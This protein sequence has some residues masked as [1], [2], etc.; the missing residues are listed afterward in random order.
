MRK[1]KKIQ[2]QEMIPEV[3]HDTLTFLEM[4]APSIVRFNIDHFICGNTYRCIWAVREYP[5]STEEQAILHRLGEKDG[6]TLKIYTRHVTALEE[7]KI[8]HN[9]SNRNRMRQNT[10]DM[11]ENITASS[12]LQ[13]VETIITT[14]HRNREP[15]LHTAVYIELTANDMEKLKL[16]QT[17]VETELMRSKLNVDKLLMRQKEGF[18]C[19]MPTGC[20]LFKEQFERVLP[21]SSVANL[22]PFAYSGKTDPNGFYLGKDKYGSNILVDFEKRESD[23]TNS[24]IL[25]LGNSGQGKSYLLKLILTCLRE[26]GK[27]IVCLDPEFEYGELTKNLGGTYI[28]LM[29]GEYIINVLEPKLWHDGS[30]DSKEDEDAP[31]TFKQQSRMSQHIS[32]L[33]DFFRSYKDFT[34]AQIDTIEIMLEQLY[35]DFNISDETDFSQMNPSD[36]PILSDLY[37]LCEREFKHYDAKQKKLYTADMLREICLGLHSMCAG[38]ESRFFNGHTNVETHR[39]VTFGCKGL[40]ESSKNLKNALLFN[41]LS[42]MSNALLTNGNTVASI[43]EMYLFLSNYVA[44]EYI[45]NFSK[46]VRKKDS[47]VILASQNVEDF[48][49]DNIRELT[50]PLFAIPTHAFLFNAGNT[51][52]KVYMETLQLQKSEYDIIRHPARGSC[53]YKC[54]NERY[55]LLVR[56]PGYKSKLFGDAGGR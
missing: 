41:V 20:N 12:N 11:Q 35:Q 2:K 44:V 13:D 23:K 47:A 22:Y 9:A 36:Y 28:D 24:N 45:R 43:D 25:I 30:T 27:H 53:L 4:I 5:T 52:D 33:R 38:A 3:N 10:T 21:A 7:K 50:K 40:L 46:R 26:S 8:I 48:L 39:F 18:I 19:V 17:E 1:V 55:N 49:Q 6:I 54:G 37:E 56:A 14:M 32:F 34:D 42:Y 51:S 31:A 29:S 16:L 15:L